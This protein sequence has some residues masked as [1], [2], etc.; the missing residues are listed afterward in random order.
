MAEVGEAERPH[1]EGHSNI[2]SL[3]PMQGAAGSVSS[4]IGERFSIQVRD[5]SKTQIQFTGFAGGRV[6]AQAAQ[7]DQG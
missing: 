1:R 5:D 4:K 3:S 7:P 2:G 6:L